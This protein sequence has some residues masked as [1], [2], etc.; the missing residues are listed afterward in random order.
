[1]IAPWKGRRIL[2]M[3]RT[4]SCVSDLHRRVAA[5]NLLTKSACCVRHKKIHPPGARLA[6]RPSQNCQ[7]R[8]RRMDAT[9]P[10]WSTVLFT[11]LLHT[12][13]WV[14]L[15]N[16]CSPSQPILTPFLGD[17]PILALAHVP[18]ATH[19]RT[20]PTSVSLLV[21]SEQLCRSLA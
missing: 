7:N 13:R 3:L 20:K 8:R 15:R 18:S 19:G 10:S 21:D 5:P 14:M 12:A 6:N 1:M 4:A 11:L 9:R 2:F 17:Q 16:S